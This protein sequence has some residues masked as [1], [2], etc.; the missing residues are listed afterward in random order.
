MRIVA[1]IPARMES[2]RFPGKPLVPILGLP[3]IEHIR[4]RVL[5]CRELDDVIVATCNE[6]IYRTV[7]EAGGHVVMTANTHERCTDRIAEA[8]RGIKADIIVNVQ[9]DEVLIRPDMVYAVAKPMVEDPDLLCVNMITPVVDEAEF[10][11]PNAPKV[12]KDQKGNIL[13][14]TRE[15]VPSDKKAPSKDYEKFKQL[16]LIA[17]RS[18]FLQ[19]FT[20][21]AP[22]P[23]EIIESVDMM[24]AIEHG[25]SVRAII[26]HHRMISI[27]VP[28]Q[29]PQA[30]IVLKNDPFV[31]QYLHRD[32]ERT[33]QR[34]TR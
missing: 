34:T 28:D 29:V 32:N 2:M 12:V 30:E 11:D 15:A 9:G 16:G 31:S 25:Y 20:K 13:Y 4:R 17:F 8:A 19:L 33:S 22:T 7:K 6:E 5:L 23:L 10:R 14:I 27:D 26:N 18:D 3:M 1:I 24:R 21:L